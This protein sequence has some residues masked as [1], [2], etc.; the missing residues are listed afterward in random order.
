MSIDIHACTATGRQTNQNGFTLAEFLIASLIL[1]VV[2]SA[3][4]SLLS[5]IQRT[6]SYQSEVQAVLNNTRIAMETIERHIRQA[7][8]DPLGSG[9]PGITIVSANEVQIRS[10]LTGSSGAGNPDKGDPDGDVDDSDENVTIRYNGV[11]RSLEIVPD[12]GSPQIAA[13]YISGLSFQYYDATGA[14]TADSK[15]VRTISF[16][17]TGS[18]LQP[19]PQ[20]RRIFGIRL[21]S[22]IR[23]PG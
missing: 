7:G 19:D 9:L 23:M 4:F 22:G 21:S 16:T 1:L 17:V 13:G 8:N 15:D 6:A 12:G 18:T 2:A 20:T 5:E 11:S 3:A 14:V 10:D